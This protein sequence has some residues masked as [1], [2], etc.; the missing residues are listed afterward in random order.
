M[1]EP[2]VQP[3]ETWGTYCVTE[4]APLFREAVAINV[5][6]GRFKTGHGTLRLAA[7]TA[8]ATPPAPQ[9]AEDHRLH[10]KK[11]VTM[12]PGWPEGTAVAV[13]DGRILSVGVTFDDLKPWL[14]KYPYEV[15]DRFKD[16]V[17]YPGFVEAHSHPV[18]GSLAHQPSVA[19]LLPVA[20][21][22]WRRHSGREE[23]ATRRSHGS[24]N[25][26]PMPSRRTRRS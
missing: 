22:L 12:D 26:S 13:M 7:V 8:P 15:D 20:Q 10:A 5:N 18:M 14:D 21:S 3:D 16:K 23:P 19:Q 25:T 9:T 1:A 6:L 4:L 2:N 17:I 24:S 11:F